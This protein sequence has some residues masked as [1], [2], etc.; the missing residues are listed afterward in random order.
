MTIDYDELRRIEAAMTPGPWEG[1]DYLVSNNPA[2]PIECICWTAHNKPGRTTQALAN[3]RGIAAMR[4]AL[5]TLLDD[6]A[7]LRADLSIALAGQREDRETL[8]LLRARNQELLDGRARDEAR[9][10][11]AERQHGEIY[12]RVKSVVESLLADNRWLRARVGELEFGIET[13][14]H[15]V[16]I[17]KLAEARRPCECDNKDSPPTTAN[18]Y[19]FLLSC[20]WADACKSADAV[21]DD[22]VFTRWELLARPIVE[23]L[24]E[25]RRDAFAKDAVEARTRELQS[26]AFAAKGVESDGAAPKP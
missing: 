25:A 19:L 17:Q 20:Y 10:I 21:P 1:R 15:A 26:A 16:T 6:L 18:D 22:D 14:A 4:N 24:A 12:V 5:P 7:A 13:A 3:A 23:Q 8:A 11:C 9:R 2:L